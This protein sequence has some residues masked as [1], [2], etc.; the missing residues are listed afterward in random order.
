[1]IFLT[2]III[3]LIFN[4]AL[5][6]SVSFLLKFIEKGMLNAGYD[7]FLS[8]TVIKSDLMENYTFMR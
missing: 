7:D 6:I 1:M 4:L 3:D 2:M 8:G 5:I